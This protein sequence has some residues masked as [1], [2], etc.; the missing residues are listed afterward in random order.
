MKI[1][2]TQLKQ[3]IKEELGAMGEQ[4]AADYPNIQALLGP[5]LY[6]KV[7]DQF[8]KDIE[9]A[10][11]DKYMMGGM[12]GDYRA[13]DHRF[14]DTLEAALAAQPDLAAGQET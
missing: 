2:K 3:I 13:D 7:M 6:G 5:E 1:T 14:A 9:F 8:E 4:P 11:K 10:V 12:S